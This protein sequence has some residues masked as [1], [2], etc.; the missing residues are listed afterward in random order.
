MSDQQGSKPVMK[1]QLLRESEEL[2]IQLV[3]PAEAAADLAF[4]ASD[5]AREVLPDNDEARRLIKL[6]EMISIK[7][8]DCLAARAVMVGP[9]DREKLA[10]AG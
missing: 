10:L 1:A 4:I 2:P 5:F 8:E 7:L 6:A 9:D 3:L